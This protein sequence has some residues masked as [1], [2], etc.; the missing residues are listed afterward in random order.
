LNQTIKDFYLKFYNME[1]TDEEVEGMF[2]PPREA[3]DGV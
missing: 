3:A 2:N 1:L